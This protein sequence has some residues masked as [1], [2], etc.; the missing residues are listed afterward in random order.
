MPVSRDDAINA[1]RFILGREPE[2]EIVIGQAMEAENVGHLRGV[3]LGSREFVEKYEGQ[4]RPQPIGRYFE[5]SDIDIDIACTPEQLR[6]MFD[7][8]AEAWRK[9][10]ETEPHWSVLVSDDYR[11]ENLAA[12]IDRFYASG[13]GDIEV[14]LNFLRRARLPTTF[15]KALD[16]GCG[17][18][19]L[20]LALAPHARQVVGVDISPPHLKLAE[21]RARDAGIGNVG[22]EAIGSVEDIDRHRGYDLVVSR[23][24]LQH[25]PPP[26]MAALYARLLAALAPG[27]VAIVQMPTYI[28]GQRFTAAEYLA[29][30]QPQME[31]NGLPQPVIYRLIEDAG[32]RLIEVRE[33]GAAGDQPALSHTFVTQR[34]P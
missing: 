24:V 19:R 13:H 31:M 14:H 7:R 29:S 34:K 32:C 1:Y 11:Q 2:S 18:G 5:I 33:D 16:F 10:G 12:N 4:G 28:H 6:S 17:V 25:N 23:I 3:F 22:F 15:A 26:V 27:G 20:T 30:E 21:E 8:I 9:F